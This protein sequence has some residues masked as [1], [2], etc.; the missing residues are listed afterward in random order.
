MIGI[1]HQQPS[2]WETF[3]ATE[4]AEL[5][6]P[7]MRA[8]DELLEETNCWAPSSRRAGLPL[9]CHICL[10]HQSADAI[11]DIEIEMGRV[12]HDRHESWLCDYRSDRSG[13]PERV[14]FG[15]RGFRA[16]M[17]QGA[18]GRSVTSFDTA[19][20][21]SGFCGA[22]PIRLLGIITLPGCI[23]AITVGMIL[24]GG[25]LTW[26]YFGE[27]QAGLRRA[28]LRSCRY[29]APLLLGNL[30]PACRKRRALTSEHNPCDLH[31]SEP[32]MSSDQGSVVPVIMALACSRPSGARYNLSLPDHA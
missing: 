15:A 12:G 14:S 26:I 21:T 16:N 29:P 4:V 17:D 32:A 1:R 18:W 22:G 28:S 2:L 20:T 7:W 30:R 24:A 11:R 9:D 5:W 6:E 19:S 23:G 3:F 27:R 25:L 10:P 31:R 8:V 13:G